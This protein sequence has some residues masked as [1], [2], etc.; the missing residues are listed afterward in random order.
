MSEFDKILDVSE[1]LIMKYGARSVT[2]SDISNELG[3]SKK[4]LYNY[5]INK[6]DLVYK[7]IVRFL[8]KDKQELVEEISSSSNALEEMMILSEHVKKNIQRVNPSLIFDLKKYHNKSFQYIQDFNKSFIYDRIHSN[9]QKGIEDKLYRSDMN[10]DIVTRIYF[11]LMPI[12]SDDVL[13]PLN[14]FNRQDLYQEMVNYH[15]Y[16]IISDKGLKLLQQYTQEK[17][18]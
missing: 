18:N 12:F 11:G 17:N 13:F 6:D 5:V 8:D 10:I 1:N 15:I 7:M 14:E 9:L 3:M 4:T 2:M 16:S